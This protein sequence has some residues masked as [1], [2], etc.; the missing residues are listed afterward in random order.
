MNSE[1][2]P[3]AALSIDP[4]SPAYLAEFLGYQR[5]LLKEAEK[6][7][8]HPLLA[9]DWADEGAALVQRLRGELAAVERKVEAYEAAAP[10]LEEAC[11]ALATARAEAVAAKR[12]REV[13]GLERS[14]CLRLRD[15]E[16]V[17]NQAIAVRWRE[18]QDAVRR[19]RGICPTNAGRPSVSGDDVVR[20]ILGFVTGRGTPIAPRVWQRLFAL[21]DDEMAG[22][23]LHAARAVAELKEATRR[24]EVRTSHG[25]FRDP[26]RVE[27]EDYASAFV[28]ELRAFKMSRAAHIRAKVASAREDLER[29]S[30][31][32]SA[33]AS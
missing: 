6:A 3:T 7:A 4:H 31:A 30:A 2:S 21:G 33:V 20:I 8:A 18:L 10:V 23:P 27:D 5:S 16:E 19:M 24:G 29:A 26:R 14:E 17:A 1:L 13:G 15:D 25:S 28:S 22:I 12:A 32:G 9:P 11:A